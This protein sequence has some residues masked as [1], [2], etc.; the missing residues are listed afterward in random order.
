MEKPANRCKREVASHTR[1]IDKAKPVLQNLHPLLTPCIGF[2]SL[3]TKGRA[4]G[5]RAL[6]L[7]KY[8]R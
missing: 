3:V 2:A 5:L 1:Q 4:L 7:C 6:G 8:P